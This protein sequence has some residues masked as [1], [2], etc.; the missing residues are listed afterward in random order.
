MLNMMIFVIKFN[1]TKIQIDSCY[2]LQS[3]IKN[4]Y[5]AQNLR[6][7]IMLKTIYNILIN[8]NQKIT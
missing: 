2:L 1:L 7:N 4:L 8:Y 6:L 5:M 3:F